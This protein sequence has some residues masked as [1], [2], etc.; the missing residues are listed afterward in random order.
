MK[1]RV[2]QILLSLLLCMALPIA[3][4][5][6]TLSDLKKQ[7][8]ETQQQLNNV[9]G[10]IAN[11]NQQKKG[12]TEEINELD[13]QM[14]EVIASVSMLEDEIEELE[15]KIEQAQS[16]YDAAKQK[17]DE[18]YEAMK[19][20]MKYMYEKGD[21]S[22]V[23]LLL[24]SKNLSEMVNK[25]DYIEKVYEYDQNMLEEFQKVKEEVAEA[26]QKLEDEQSEL[27]TS[28][29]ELEQ[30][31]EVLDTMIAE[32]KAQQADFDTQL[33]KAKQEAAAYKAK[34]KQQN[35][36]I[37][38]LEAE[39]AKKA[40]STKS[41][42]G[43]SG[44]DSASIISGATG[45]ASG[46]EIASY[47]CKFVGNPYVAGGTSLTNGADCSGFTY[48]VYQAFGYSIPRTSTAQRSAGKGVNYSEAQPGDI[49]CYAGHVALY[50]GGGRIVHASTPSTGIK[51][52]TATYREILAVRRIV[53]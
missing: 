53:G 18:Q 25:A 40:A 47:A 2:S 23:Q 51:Y 1:K 45:S 52:G 9:N 41:S 38:K 32:K 35:S 3:A 6:T 26:K 5:A 8:Q 20:R 19:I 42:S 37:K 14:V 34:I 36:E 48:A 15:D 12:I 22:Y 21:T 24:E 10:T 27:V 28:K 46:K 31:K 11:L 13:D 49:I 7:Q 17:E 39:A 4:Q 50:I 29:Y 16:E 33:A 30:E 44:V 43:S